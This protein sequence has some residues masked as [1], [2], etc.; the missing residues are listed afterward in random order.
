M[1][2]SK[3][4]ENIVDYFLFTAAEA[5]AFISNLKL[6]KLVYY[7]QAWHLV[8]F[9]EPV[10]DDKIEAWVHGPVVRELYS[11]YK[12]YG[13]MPIPPP[14]TEVEISDDLKQF[15]TEIMD[16]F[17]KYDGFELEKMTH[18]EPP[19]IIARGSLPPDANSDS[20]ITNSSMIDYFSKLA[21][22]S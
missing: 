18:S 3:E 5:G 7:A 13:W 1:S 8:V 4:L 22:E 12:D 2:I 14:E 9:N 19:W 6:Q 20:E 10:F 17:M 21:E 11:K 16:I 15:L